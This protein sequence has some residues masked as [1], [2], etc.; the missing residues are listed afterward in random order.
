ME[1]LPG[2][3]ASVKDTA[4]KLYMSR[5]TLFRKLQ[6]ERTSYREILSECRQKLAKTYI[7]QADL[8]LESIA[9]LLGYSEASAFQKAFGRWYGLTPGEYRK[10]S[11]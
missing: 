3:S 10:Q 2:G 4:A 6:Q 1:S 9:F 8:S 11:F 5:Q 7:Q